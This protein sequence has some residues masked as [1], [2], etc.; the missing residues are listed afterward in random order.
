MMAP[1]GTPVVAIY[2]GVILQ[3]RT[4]SLGGLTI[5]MRSDATS[6]TTPTST[7]TRQVSGRA[8]RWRRARRSDSWGRRGTPRT[9]S[10]IS[11]SSSIRTAEPRSIRIRSSTPS[12]AEADATRGPAGDSGPRVIR[13]LLPGGRE[14]RRVRPNAPTGERWC[15][16]A[17]PLEHVP[18]TSS[19]ADARKPRWISE[20][21]Q[22]T[23]QCRPVC[24]RVGL[25]R[26][27]GHR[28]TRRLRTG[29]RGSPSAWRSCRCR[30]RRLPGAPARAASPPPRRTPPRRG[31]TGRPA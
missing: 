29:L 14:P 20:S 1:R 31:W 22:L 17:S 9:T 7:A 28:S 24:V 10:P 6:T 26:P 27:A 25:C 16:P 11:T 12:A 30:S 3:V 13:G 4:S 5:W 18:I 15:L 23:S 19:V 2:G 21:R 8:W